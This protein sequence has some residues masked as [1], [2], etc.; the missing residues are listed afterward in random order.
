MADS[1]DMLNFVRLFFA[2]LIHPE[3]IDLRRPDEVL[4]LLPESYAITDCKSLYDALEK[5][6]SLGLGLSEKRTSIEVM[7]T[8][9]QMRATGI[10]TRWVNSDRQLADVLTKTTAPTGSIL[11]LQSSGRWKIVWDE[12]YTSA[13][14]VR[15]AKR[16]AYL[17]R[18][19]NRPTTA[20]NHPHSHFASKRK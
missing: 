17:E 1:V 11:K 3:G 10:Q 14:N 9:Q 16:D 6:E 19:S 8:R 7:A 4:K 5:N 2:D 15:K 18:V 12:N 20:K 13:K